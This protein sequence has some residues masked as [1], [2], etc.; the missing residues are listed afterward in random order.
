MPQ[1][2]VV[3]ASALRQSDPLGCAAA[4]AKRIAARAGRLICF[5]LCPRTHHLHH[6]LGAGGAPSGLEEVL[7]GGCSYHL[8]LRTSG[9]DQRIQV[10]SYRGGAGYLLAT[11]RFLRLCK[12]ATRE[13]SQVLVTCAL[14]QGPWVGEIAAWSDAFVLVSPSDLSAPDLTLPICAAPTK[15]L[16]LASGAEPPGAEALADRLGAALVGTVCEPGPEASATLELA[17]DLAMG[18]RGTPE[19]LLAERKAV[20]MG[21]LSVAKGKHALLRTGRRWSDTSTD[22]VVLE[23]E[24]QLLRQRLTKLER[25][26]QQRLSVA[27]G[28]EQQ[29]PLQ[30]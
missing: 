26:Y 22:L 9:V 19:P 27:A 18:A 11:A 30:D 15:R 10:V 16:L 17:A 5:D 1:R 29:P 28:Q 2:F 20:P 13:F 7:S 25:L 12:Q 3:L 24:I 8:H 6:H 23:H 21:P 4:I 14:D